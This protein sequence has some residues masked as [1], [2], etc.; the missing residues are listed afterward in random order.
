MGMLFLLIS[1]LLPDRN[2]RLNG[3]LPQFM[4]IFILIIMIFNRSYTSDASSGTSEYRKGKFDSALSNF[5]KAIITD[6]KNEKFRFNEGDSYYQLQKFDESAASFSGLSNSKDKIIRDKTIYNYGN[7]LLEKQDYN[8]AINSYRSILEGEEKNSGV[9]KKALQNFLF[10]K[11][12]IREQK[13]NNQNNKDNKDQKDKNKD[14]KNNNKNQDNRN[15]NKKSQDKQDQKQQQTKPISPS[16]IDNLLNL[17]QEEEKK[18]LSKKE[19][20][21]SIRVSPKYEW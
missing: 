1:I 21:K 9:Y 15:N 7:S 5:Q 4:I 8:G 14:N 11:E 2:I 13:Q 20:D 17:I 16:D 10:A 18:H 12:Q 19:M 3:R 6:P